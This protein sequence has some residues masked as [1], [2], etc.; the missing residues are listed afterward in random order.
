MA[1]ALA[2]PFVLEASPGKS[3]LPKLCS[4][5]AS[6]LKGRAVFPPPSKHWAAC[7]LSTGL[8]PALTSASMLKGKEQGTPMSPR[9][10]H[11]KL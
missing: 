1:L 7:D 5:Q 2:A 8:R 11:R 3:C 6:L 4:H 10:G 9:G